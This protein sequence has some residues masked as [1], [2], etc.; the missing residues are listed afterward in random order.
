MSAS[1]TTTLGENVSAWRLS[2]ARWGATDPVLSCLSSS[3]IS[4]ESAAH[5]KLQLILT[6]RTRRFVRKRPGRAPRGTV[7]KTRADRGKHTRRINKWAHVRKEKWLEWKQQC[8]KVRECER[9]SNIFHGP[10]VM[11]RFEREQTHSYDRLTLNAR[12]VCSCEQWGHLGL[13]LQS[14]ITKTFHITS[15]QEE[16]EV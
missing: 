13:W 3:S 9:G 11:S 12:L 5:V 8:V 2:A 6:L 15:W 10:G 14:E 4:R 1:T 7:G 16:E